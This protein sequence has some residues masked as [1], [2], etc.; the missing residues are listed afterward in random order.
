MCGIVGYV[1]TRDCLAILIEGIKRLEYRGYD[2]AG[3][4][5]Q[6]S[7]ELRVVKSAGKIRALEGRLKIGIR[8]AQQTVRASLADAA[9]ARVLETRIGSPL[10]SI[11][12][13]RGRS[14]R[15]GYLTNAPRTYGVSLNINF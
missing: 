6:T 8:D 11:D 15:V 5:V 1:G 14:A 12:R 10:L 9:L 3:V 13:E 2:S 7:S 4:A